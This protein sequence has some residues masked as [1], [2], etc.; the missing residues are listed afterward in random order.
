MIMAVRRGH[1]SITS[2]LRDLGTE[3]PRKNEYAE[4]KRLV[5]ANGL[6]KP[7]AGYFVTKIVVNAVLV[8]LGLFGL[9]LAGSSAWWWLADVVFL[10][11]VFVQIALLGHDVAHLQFV[12]AG[13]VNTALALILGN[14]VVGVSRAWWKHNHDAHHARPNDLAHHPNVNIAFLACSPEQALARPRWVRWIIR[15]QVALL[16]PIFCLEFFSMHQQSV[17]YALRRRRGCARAELPMLLGHYVIYGSVLVGALGLSGTLMFA[18]VHHVLTGL[19]MA[20]IFAPNHKG[21]PLAPTSHSAGEFLREQV[22]TARNIRG[23]WFIDLVY[24]GLNYQIEHHLF[25]SMP[26]NNLRSARSLVQAYC[27]LHGVAYHETSLHG[28]WREIVAHFG[29]VSRAL[30]SSEYG[31][32]EQAASDGRA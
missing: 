31:V 13:R 10:S 7:Q 24:G 8:V 6:L 9:R 32:A 18:L 22:L 27:L 29:R 19:Y 28:S 4:L 15:H 17:Q 30:I 21:M 1:V 25:P 3:Q 2:E 26:R 12:R 23:N 16:I 14:L 5:E 11:F 20:T